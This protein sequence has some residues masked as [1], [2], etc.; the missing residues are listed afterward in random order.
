MGR[1]TKRAAHRSHPYCLDS[2]SRTR[3][4]STTA[5]F[6]CS[7]TF[8]PDD[9]NGPRARSP[10]LSSLARSQRRGFERPIPPLITQPTPFLFRE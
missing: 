9:V 7:A 2:S 3:P 8:S 4:T 5:D 10:V 1:P 6:D